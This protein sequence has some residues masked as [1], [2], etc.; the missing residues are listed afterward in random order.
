MADNFTISGNFCCLWHRNPVSSM[1]D[2]WEEVSSVFRCRTT[3]RL[4][5][6]RN[7]YIIYLVYLLQFLRISSRVTLLLGTAGPFL[8]IWIWKRKNRSREQWRACWCG[9][10]D[11]LMESGAKDISGAASENRL[12]AV[13]SGKTKAM[14]ACAAGNSSA[15]G[16]N[17]S[18]H[19]CVWTEYGGNVRLQNK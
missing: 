14:A 10:N 11:C 16:G 15:A 2:P 12:R 8:F 1:A 9:S 5:L 19:V 18:D 7:F 3:D 13:F 6:R 4:F 17:C